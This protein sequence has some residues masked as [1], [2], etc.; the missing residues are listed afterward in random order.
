VPGTVD[1]PDGRSVIARAA[2]G[3]VASRASAAVVAVP[4]APLV[5]R[6]RRP[7]DR[8]RAGGR[9]LS[10]KRFLMDRRV[11]A[12]ERGALPLM[13][14]GSRV[15]WVAGQQVDGAGPDRRGYVRLELH[16]ASP[17]RHR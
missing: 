4:D 5:V 15:L 13:A 8:V 10:L 3:P 2:R 9:E 14:A 11:P 12:H 17:R 16:D 1:L 6:T 7:G